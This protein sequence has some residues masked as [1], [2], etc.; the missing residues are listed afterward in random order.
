MYV[1]DEDEDLFAMDVVDDMY[2][3]E[4]KVSCVERRVKGAPLPAGRRDTAM[5]Y[6]VVHGGR[7]LM[8][9]RVIRSDT[10]SEFAVFK[11]DF[12]SSLWAKVTSVGDDT[13]LFV[14]RGG[15]TAR[16]LSRYDLSRYA[17]R[18]NRIYFLDDDEYF[19]LRSGDTGVRPRRRGYSDHFGAYDMKDGKTYPLLPP[20]TLCNRGEVPVTWLFR[21]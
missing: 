21:R 15:S 17:L 14:G 16:C 12:G 7:L 1:V 9:R 5:Q 4:P 2:T 13:A 3:R 20:L 11:A 6:L 10:T 8:V 18:G 19:S